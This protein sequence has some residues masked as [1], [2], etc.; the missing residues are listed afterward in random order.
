MDLTCQETSASQPVKVAAAARNELSKAAD[1]INEGK[2]QKAVAVLQKLVGK[3][4]KNIAARRCLAL[5]YYRGG[6]SESAILELKKIIA[7]DPNNAEHYFNSGFIYHSQGENDPAVV[8]YE[9][10]LAL[11]SGNLKYKKQLGETLFGMADSLY[12]ARR[13][14]LDNQEKIIGYLEK[15]IRLQSDHVNGHELLGR[16]FEDIGD[17][18]TAQGN[19]EAAKTNYEKSRDE[20][21][22]TVI[23]DPGH[24]ASLF[25]AKVCLALERNDLA[26][27]Y[28]KSYLR[29][30]DREFTILIGILTKLA[31]KDPKNIELRKLLAIAYHRSSQTEL[32]IREYKQIMVLEPNRAENY[33]NLGVL[34]RARGL[35]EEAAQSFERAVELEPS[36]LEYKKDLAG[37]YFSMAIIQ[38]ATFDRSRRSWS[39]MI[40]YLNRSIRYEPNNA[41]AYR[42]LGKVYEEI[43]EYWKSHSNLK[44]AEDYYKKAQ[45]AYLEMRKIEEKLKAKVNPPH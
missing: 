34:Y 22:K 7:L 11:D 15:L 21:L 44:K 40:D 25:L 1:L 17:V 14:R 32:A 31:S 8:N 24:K 39:R 30:N 28:V 33:S 3:N 6:Q 26:L 43:A 41:S 38:Y 20:Y 9:K 10:A 37:I 18:L 42:L 45:N 19:R 13:S 35:Q 29:F 12:A 4:R 5:A 2:P 27:R 23:L 36:R 16:V